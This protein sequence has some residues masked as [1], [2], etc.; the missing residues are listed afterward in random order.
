M[1]MPRMIGLLCGLAAIGVAVVAL[2]LEQA[3]DL[4]E[5]QKIQQEQAR[6]EQRIRS[7]NME[8]AHLRSP[9][10]VRARAAELGIES[11]PPAPPEKKPV[12]AVAPP[13]PGAGRTGGN[14]ASG[15]RP[16]ARPNR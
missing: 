9:Q 12:P 16:P 14:R 10:Q 5:V 7:Q 13:R 1:T 4:R 15:G 3:Q 8:L 11:Q 6:L 2:R